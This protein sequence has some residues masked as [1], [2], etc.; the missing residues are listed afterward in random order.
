MSI[1]KKVADHATSEEGA[2]RAYRALA[3]WCDINNWIGSASWFRA[4]AKDEL[5]HC[6]AFEEYAIDRGQISVVGPQKTLATM[7]NARLVDA[8]TAALELEKKVMAELQTL[9]SNAHNE[10]DYDVVRF[11]QEYL[12]IGVKSIKDLEV[13][14]S[15]LD[16]AGT[17]QAALQAFD[18]EI[19]TT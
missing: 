3:N 19:A 6:M 11:L 9:S 17:D 4:E 12:A 16:R 10:G 1:L 7:E 13:H 14:V 8:F 5:A 18:R 15:W 2:S